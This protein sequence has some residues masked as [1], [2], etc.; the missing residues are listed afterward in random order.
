MQTFTLKTVGKTHIYELDEAERK[1][2]ITCKKYGKDLWKNEFDLQELDPEYGE[3]A[4]EPPRVFPLLLAWC[5]AALGLGLA[6]ILLFFALRQPWD[7]TLI[8]FIV[9]ILAILIIG[10]P[11]PFFRESLFYIFRDRAKE[12][13]GF[14]YFEGSTTQSGMINIEYLLKNRAYAFE[15]VNKISALCR[16]SQRG[17][18]VPETPLARCRFD[19]IYAELYRDELKLFNDD[20]I[21]INS[22]KLEELVS[23]IVHVETSHKV[24]N[25]ICAFLAWILYLI[26]AGVVIAA[27]VASGDWII[28]AAMLI[29]SSLP[30]AIG[31]YIWKK[32]CPEENY[33]LLQWQYVPDH[34]EDIVL[35]VIPGRSAE[36]AGFIKMLEERMRFRKSRGGSGNTEE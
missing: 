34:F 15:L 21:K 14:F 18:T 33:Y 17:F 7:K 2:F 8:G 16:S 22:F 20:H 4:P 36:A 28:G 11:V 3:F 12:Q 9:F 26:P 30:W 6:G 23:N 27:W 31:G 29:C 1:L 35:D 19:K 5:V 32:R 10:R 25:L 13:T 24:R